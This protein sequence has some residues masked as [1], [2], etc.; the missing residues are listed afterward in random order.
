MKKILLVLVV[1]SA[2]VSCKV[3]TIDKESDAVV[4]TEESDEERPMF[5]VKLATG[6]VLEHVYAE[7]IAQGLLDGKWESDEDL[8]LTHSFSYEVYVEDD[9]LHILDKTRR[10]GVVGLNQIRVLDSIFIKDNE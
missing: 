10:V 2:V 3:Q 5:T 8:T 7:E 4:I 6:R 9:S 1:I